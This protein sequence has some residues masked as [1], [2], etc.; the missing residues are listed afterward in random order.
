MYLPAEVA[1]T[2]TSLTYLDEVNQIIASLYLK[3]IEMKNTD[4]GVL[5]D[6]NNSLIIGVSEAPLDPSPT[7]GDI[8]YKT[9]GNLYNEA[10]ESGQFFK[11]APMFRNI[12]GTIQINGGGEGIQIFY[13]Y[14]YF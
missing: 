4:V 11:I 7:D 9:S 10:V 8:T 6:T 14:L 13:D 5:I 12:T 2:S 1:N 3:P